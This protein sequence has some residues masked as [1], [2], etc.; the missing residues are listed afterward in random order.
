MAV[1]SLQAACLLPSSGS[2]QVQTGVTIRY[3]EAKIHAVETGRPERAGEGRTL[4]LAPFANAHDHGRG[5]KTL[6]YGVPDQAVESWVAATYSLPAVDPYLVAAAAFARMARSGIGSVVHCHLSRDPQT[7]LREAQAVSRA[8]REVGI[9]VAF[10]VP[11]RD[12]H[13]LAYA[14]DEAVLAHMDAGD[15]ELTRRRLKPIAPIAEQLA[16]ADAIA[17]ICESELFQV[18]FGPVGVEWCSNPLL[19]QVAARSAAGGRRVHMHL[20][21][22]KYQR[23]WAD[24]AF[25]QGI[26]NH[27]D[28]IGLLSPRL[29]VAHGTWLRPDECALLAARGVIVSINTSSNLRLRS[30]IAPLPQ[31][32]AAGLDFAIG[33]DALALDDDDDLLREMRLTHLLHAGTGFD[34]ALHRST[35]LHAASRNGARAASCCGGDGEIAAGG[36]ADMLLLNLDDVAQDL[37]PDLCDIPSILHARATASSVRSLIVAGRTV[38]DDGRL[39]GIDEAAVRSALNAE[40]RRHAPELARQ[41]PDMERYRAALER[42]YRAG[43][44]RT[45][46]RN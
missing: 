18:Q 6:A 42:F 7:L 17:E 33:L 9:R 43:E 14:D 30:G 34:Q 28:A 39:T 21:E 4:I 1:H 11:L 26:V 32:H 23:E 13:R 16:V 22:S 31:I 36:P 25:P 10:V 8:A 12:R 5:L 19:E 37:V 44:H 46:V 27:L 2:E 15:A 45:S 35:I 41:V 24:H 38:L 3:D 29:T 20:L 40:L